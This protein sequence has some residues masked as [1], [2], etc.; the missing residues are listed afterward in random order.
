MIAKTVPLGL[1]TLLS[2]FE[3]TTKKN[4]RIILRMLDNVLIQ[5]LS[6]KT[7]QKSTN[8]YYVQFIIFRPYF[9]WER[10]IFKSNVFFYKIFQ[11]PYVDHSCSLREL[12]ELCL[13][14]GRVHLDCVSG[15]SPSILVFLPSV[16]LLSRLGRESTFV[17]NPLFRPDNEFCNK[18]SIVSWIAEFID[19]VI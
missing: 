8:F 4:M 6:A 19:S 11:A 2:A 7:H 5:Y 17:P 15:I 13:E 3:V 12:S 9:I 10:K 18:G 14:W 1:K 16:F